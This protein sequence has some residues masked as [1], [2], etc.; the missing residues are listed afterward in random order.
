MRREWD[1]ISKSNFCKSVENNGDLARERHQ[2]SLCPNKGV[3]HNV[4]LA[5]DLEF[6]GEHPQHNKQ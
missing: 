2:T 4:N 5:N 6:L 3:Q 1:E